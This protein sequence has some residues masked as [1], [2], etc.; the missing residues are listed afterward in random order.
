MCYSL[1]FISIAIDC[2]LLASE[3]WLWIHIS[4][5]FPR[6]LLVCLSWKCCCISFF[7]RPWIIPTFLL[8]RPK[9]QLK[10]ISDDEEEKE[11]DDCLTWRRIRFDLHEGGCFL[12]VP[13][14]I[15]IA[16]F[17]VRNPLSW[18]VFCRMITWLYVF[19]E[20]LVKYVFFLLP[21]Q[22]FQRR[23]FSLTRE[24]QANVLKVRLR[25]SSGRFSVCVCSMC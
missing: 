7:P 20:A 4:R 8:N 13:T 11:E 12:V 5:V 1:Y 24:L 10:C 14:R 23:P 9:I 3:K 17:T 22:T 18:Q 21:S 6:S 19:K 16:L 25:W 2:F 15:S